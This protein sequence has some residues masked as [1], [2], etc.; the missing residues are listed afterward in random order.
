MTGDR[1][2]DAAF[3]MGAGPNH[4]DQMPLINGG[5]VGL[6]VGLQ[7]MEVKFVFDRKPRNSSKDFAF[8]RYRGYFER[9]DGAMTLEFATKD[10]CEAILLFE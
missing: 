8:G 4:G 5:K 3:S 9:F 6:Y 1:V 10:M 2:T 7:I